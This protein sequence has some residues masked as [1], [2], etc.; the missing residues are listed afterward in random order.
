VGNGGRAVH[1]VVIPA[2]LLCALVTLH[3]TDAPR[4]L[5]HPVNGVIAETVDFSSNSSTPSESGDPEHAPDAVDLYGNEITDAVAQ[6]ELD[7]TG[8]LYELHSPQTE[9]PR[10][11]S[12]KS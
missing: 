5:P 12:P 1:I 3:L 7:A 6:Y 8:S 2:F 11:P 10:L 9:L 4:T